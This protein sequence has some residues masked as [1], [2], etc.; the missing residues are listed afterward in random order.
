MTLSGVVA[1]PLLAGIFIYGG[2]DALRHPETKVKAADEVAPA[3]ASALGLPG[4]DTETLVRANG[5]LQVVAGTML[6]L[7]KARRLSAMALAASLIPTTYAG[8]RFWDEIDE[9]RRAQQRIHFLKNLA[10]LG[11]LILAASDTGGRASI[12]WRASQVAKRALSSDRGSDGTILAGAGEVASQA[13]HLAGD[14][15]GQALL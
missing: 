1:R 4:A 12:P 5:A 15:A 7:G 8:H 9:E 11:G 2:V 3:I 14:V 13:R 10:E 6:G